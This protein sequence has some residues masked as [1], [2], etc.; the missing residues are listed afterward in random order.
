MKRGFDVGKD[1]K[2]MCVVDAPFAWNRTHLSVSESFLLGLPLATLPNEN[3][4]S[5]DICIYA[6]T[7]VNKCTSSPSHSTYRHLFASSFKEFCI[8]D[9]LLV[10]VF[11]IN[12]KVEFICSQTRIQNEFKEQN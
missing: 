10:C 4:E 5:T 9:N 3:I 1:K 2:T 6:Q 11:E 12:N 7:R 8:R